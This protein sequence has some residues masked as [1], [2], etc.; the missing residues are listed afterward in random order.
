VTPP[1]SPAGGRAAAAKPPRKRSARSLAVNAVLVAVAFG[2]LGLAVY[3]SRVKIGEV[4]ARG[5][6]YRLFALAFLVYLAGV[7]LSFVR[8]Y[9][10]VRVIEPRFT[11]APAFLLGFIGIVFNL[12]IPG[13]VGGDFI[14][15]AY[16][17]RMD[18]NRTQAIASMVIDRIIGL[19]GLFLLAGVAGGFA[20]GLATR[21]VRVLI[22]VDWAAVA[23]GFALI[24]VIF[25]QA[26]TRTFPSLTKGHRKSAGVFHELSVMS[27]T[28][29]RRLDVV[30][31]A[32]AVSLAIHGLMVVAF[33]LASRAIFHD[34]LPGFGQ[35]LL[36]VPLTLFTTAVPIPGGALGFTENISDQLF[37]LVNHPGG[38][39]AMMGFRVLMYAG[40]LVG[41]GVYLA[42]I[43]K[44]RSLTETAELLK[45]EL[46]ENDLDDPAV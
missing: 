9:A 11:P 16:L 10:L 36:I 7:T 21:P 40:A 14:K 24:T 45:E 15:A 41:T 20:W 18:I 43:R 19:L 37:K 6:D 32:L 27:T 31:G 4:F 1:G 33:Y 39:V 35:H 25:T 23:C 44:V 12:V 3:Q 2:L 5:I 17:V 42:K 29:R 34:G 28:Y 38:A 46:D 8:W 13:A 26:V 30:A 22:A